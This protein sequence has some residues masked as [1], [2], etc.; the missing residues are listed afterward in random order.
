MCEEAVAPGLQELGVE[1][2]VFGVAC[3][4]FAKAGR[5]RAVA[6]VAESCNISRRV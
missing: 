3:A 6:A 1:V 4:A 2:V 5:D